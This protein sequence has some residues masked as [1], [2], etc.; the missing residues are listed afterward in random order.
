M[1]GLRGNTWCQVRPRPHTPHQAA[2]PTRHQAPCDAPAL[3]RPT[4][5]PSDAPPARPLTPHQPAVRRPTSPPSDAPPGWPP[6]PHQATS[7]QRWRRVGLAAK[8]AAAGWRPGSR[9]AGAVRPCIP[10]TAAWRSWRLSTPQGAGPY[11]G[12]RLEGCRREPRAHTASIAHT[13]SRPLSRHPPIERSQRPQGPRERRERRPAAATWPQTSR[14]RPPTPPAPP[15]R[16]LGWLR[17]RA[18]LPRRVCPG[19][20]RRRFLVFGAVC[21]SCGG[22]SRPRVDASREHTLG[23]ACCVRKSGPKRAR[24]SGLSWW[25]RKN[26]E[27]PM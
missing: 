12:R 26:A 14:A 22:L 13:R 20:G 24:W 21:T 25:A 2:L 8:A 11:R 1:H 4:S 3:R 7:D 17:W 18:E 9:Y 6:T 27:S 10:S 23:A 19:I 15:A 16:P 5:P